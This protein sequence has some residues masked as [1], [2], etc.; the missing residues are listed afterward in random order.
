MVCPCCG[1]GKWRCYYRYYLSDFTVTWN[2]LTLTLNLSD[3][4]WSQTQFSSDGSSGLRIDPFGHCIADYSPRVRL[5]YAYF[6]EVK[7][8]L[9]QGSLNTICDELTYGIRATTGVT[10]IRSNLSTLFNRA[11][12]I[13][14]IVASNFKVQD[15]L[16][17]E[18]FGIQR[19]E[20]DT[21]V[22]ISQDGVVSQSATGPGTALAGS[23][24]SEG[25]YPFNTILFDLPRC[26]NG[27]SVEIEPAPGEAK[28]RTRPS[29]SGSAAK[30]LYLCSNTIATCREPI[31]G[32]YLTSTLCQSECVAPS[33]LP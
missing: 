18:Q 9:I 12:T 7:Y 6:F 2:G 33:P 30:K 10:Y 16:S 17:H 31:S 15:G 1:D 23:P 22:T 4:G 26:A 5:V 11:P 27:T 14:E 25:C 24:D 20:R 32:P 19:C 13:E 21:L 29:V 28:L 3:A 8:R